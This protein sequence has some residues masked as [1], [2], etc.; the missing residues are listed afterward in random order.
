MNDQPARSSYT[1]ELVLRGD[2]ATAICPELH[3]PADVQ[4]FATQFVQPNSVLTVVWLRGGVDYGNFLIFANEQGLA[5]V[6]LLEHQ[7]FYIK[8]TAEYE[9]GKNFIFISDVG[10]TFQVDEN[11]TVPLST[12]LE[13][14][15]YWLLQG[16][17]LPSVNW[18]EE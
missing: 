18:G 8:R 15:E 4:A 7:G 12:A 10:S 16:R 6:R 2:P 5:H 3:A 1:V 17:Q 14:L 13:A 11:Y 9:S